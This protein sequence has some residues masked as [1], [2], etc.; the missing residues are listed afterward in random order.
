MTLLVIS[1]LLPAY[2]AISAVYVTSLDCLNRA[3]EL[4][5]MVGVGAHV[6][7][8]D[9]TDGLWTARN[10]S[11]VDVALATTS[12]AADLDTRLV[13]ADAAAGAA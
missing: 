3:R 6:T 2:C 8:D 12:A 5:I 11:A 10:L 1:R 7:L 9:N 13:A 4:A